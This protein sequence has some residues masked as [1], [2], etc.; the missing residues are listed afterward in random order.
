MTTISS[1]FFIEIADY[2]SDLDALRAVREPVFV[3]EQQVPIELEWDEL[4]PHSRHVLARDPAGRPIGT[5]RLTPERK[6][7]RMAVLPEWRGRG[8]GDAMLTALTDLART[9]GY[10]EV[11]LHA[12]VSAIDFYTRAGFVAYGERFMEAGIEHQSMRRTLQP[13]A[14]P[15]RPAAAAA[16]QAP[17]RE[18]DS[19]VDC[20]EALLDLL[21]GARHRLWI[22]SRDLDPTLL[23]AP[24]PL[25]EMRRIGL[26]GRGAEIRLLLQD[27]A[28]AQQARAPLIPLLQRM[29]SVVQVR[30]PVDD[31]DLQ[32]ASAFVLSDVGGYLFRP[33]A[34]RFEGYMSP[35]GAGR[36]RQLLDYF[37]Q[38]WER[39]V[40][41]DELRV[42][43]L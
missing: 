5:G 16:E 10:R 28:A 8:V 4:D 15:E 29:S 7:G 40:L 26:S 24:E 35:H 1:D 37:R 33:L 21:R 11:A 25:E 3:V 18:F 27:P 43:R 17:E 42:M 23:N 6:I 31:V 9:L 34:S 12:Q 30:Q 41:A 14:V 39:S 19:F 2:A 22:Y 20:R 36:H 32:Y 13:L 38:V